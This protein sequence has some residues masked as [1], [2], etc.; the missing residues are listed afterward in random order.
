MNSIG[1]TDI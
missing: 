1:D